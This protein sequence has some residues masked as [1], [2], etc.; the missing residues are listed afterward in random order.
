MS[1]SHALVPA[2]PPQNLEPFVDAGILFVSS[3][4]QMAQ[5]GSIA[6]R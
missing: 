1:A 6:S 3:R 5:R 2:S 4:D